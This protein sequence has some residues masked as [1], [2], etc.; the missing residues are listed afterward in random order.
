MDNRR[1]ENTKTL[2]KTLRKNNQM[3][4]IR[5]LIEM[6]HDFTAETVK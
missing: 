1:L 6:F 2:Q 4:C 3:F 5:L